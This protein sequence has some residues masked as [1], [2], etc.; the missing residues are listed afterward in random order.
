MSALEKDLG[1]ELDRKVGG[2][3]QSLGL[4]QTESERAGQEK[5]LLPGGSWDR[6]RVET[7]DINKTGIAACQRSL[8]ALE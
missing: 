7:D 8:F 3:R 6:C 5:N 2:K 4:R 1:G